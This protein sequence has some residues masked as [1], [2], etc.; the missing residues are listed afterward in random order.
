MSA[1]FDEF[2]EQRDAQIVRHALRQWPHLE[3]SPDF[4]ARAFDNRVLE[5][6]RRE[7]WQFAPPQH[8]WTRR[9]RFRGWLARRVAPIDWTFAWRLVAC[10]V[11]GVL[12]VALFLLCNAF[13]HR[14]DNS[15]APA[16]RATQNQA[17]PR[18][19]AP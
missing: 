13:L 10:F 18:E 17:A 16:P 15:N 5:T 1:L 12:L 9:E 6:I 19:V 2:Q 11:A 8:A 3:K 14:V 4:D 7:P